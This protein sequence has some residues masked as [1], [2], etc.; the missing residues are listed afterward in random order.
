MTQELLQKM[1]EEEGS[2]S[3]L[4]IKDPNYGSVKDEAMVDSDSQQ[5]T[6]C[7]KGECRLLK[8]CVTNTVT[9]EPSHSKLRQWKSML[10]HQGWFAV[11]YTQHLL[12]SQS[13]EFEICI[14]QAL[15]MPL[16]RC[17]NI[18][19]QGRL[20]L[21]CLH[22]CNDDQAQSKNVKCC[23]GWRQSIIFI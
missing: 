22:S 10:I 12:D 20:S 18:F 17:T 2:F 7:N 21:Q 3:D 4:R 16:I 15:N 11:L 6:T 14:L 1:S 9:A 5:T 8:Y 19:F 23:P 13:F